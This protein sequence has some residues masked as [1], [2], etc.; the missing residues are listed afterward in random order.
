MQARQW[1]QDVM[2]FM[3]TRILKLSG[4]HIHH[5]ECRSQAAFAAWHMLHKL[6]RFMSYL[7]CQA[8]ATPDV[9]KIT[10]PGIIVR[11]AMS[12]ELDDVAWLR[13]EAFYEASCSQRRH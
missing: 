8:A 7:F 10:E 3:P 9:E 1:A 13:A 5:P 2:L 12:S 6:K 11:P 4:I